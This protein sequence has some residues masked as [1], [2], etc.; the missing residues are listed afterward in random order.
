LNCKAPCR[1]RKS[2]FENYV[3]TKQLTLTTQ[4]DHGQKEVIFPSQIFFSLSL[5]Y[6]SR[7]IPGQQDKFSEWTEIRVEKYSNR[8]EKRWNV[9]GISIGSYFATNFPFILTK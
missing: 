9:R 1:G 6:V 3:F 4:V 2:E 5:K 7:H 8:F